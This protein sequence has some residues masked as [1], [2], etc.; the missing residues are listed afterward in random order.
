MWILPQQLH[1][2]AFVLDT[3]A[4]TLDS[5][6]L[7]RTCERSLIRRS[8]PSQSSAYLR[9][10]KAGNL[11]RL[12]FG[13]ISSLSLGQS[14][15]EKWTSSLADIP[16]NHLAQQ[17][18]ENEQKTHDI[19]GPTSQAEFAFSSP[20]S[21]SSRT[22][23]ATSRWDSPQSLATWKNWVTKCRGAYSARLNAV[24]LTRENECSSWPT[25]NARDWKDGS[26]ECNQRAIDAGHQ[27]TL[28][29]AATCWSTPSTMAG[30]MYAEAN[31]HKRNSPSLASQVIMWPTPTAMEAEKAGLYNQGQ[32]GQSLSAMANRGELNG[33][34]D[35]ANPNTTGNRPESWPTARSLDGQVNE[36]LETWEIRQQKKAEQGINLHR[37]LPIAVAQE[38]KKQQ[39]NGKKDTLH[40]QMKAWATPRTK[41]AEG[42]MMNQARLLAGKPDDTLTG[43]VTQSKKHNGKLNPRWVETLMGLPVGWTMP[44]C[45]S[46]VTIAQTSCASSATESSQQQQP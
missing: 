30:G 1:T 13:A 31:M 39:D 34:A 19:F 9:E 29:R 28:A 11:M 41:D 20:E 21:A 24:R 33:P 17:D 15:L 8:K 44:S 18:S 27:V 12:R 6:E 26:A 37:P 16:A 3:E 5:V 2:S 22:S 14:F 45:A 43:Q 4:L 42:W 7:S 46:P 25:A 35:P 23:K 40:S 36:F 10:W 38:I 32:M